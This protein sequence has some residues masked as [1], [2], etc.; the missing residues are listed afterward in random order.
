MQTYCTIQQYALV[1]EIDQSYWSLNTCA[2][3][4][5]AGNNGMPNYFVAIKCIVHLHILLL[6][7]L[8]VVAVFQYI[9]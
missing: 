7:L 2:F 5:F 9:Q 4:A 1:V 6:F 3:F 8:S